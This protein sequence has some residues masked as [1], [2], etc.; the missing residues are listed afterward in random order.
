M[1][2]ANLSSNEMFELFD[3]NGDGFIS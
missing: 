2:T 3:T 1:K